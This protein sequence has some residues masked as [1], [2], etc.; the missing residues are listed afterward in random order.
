M[1]SGRQYALLR[2]DIWR[3]EDWRDLSVDAQWLYELLISQPVTSTAGVLPLQITKWARC[4]RGMTIERVAAAVGMLSERRYIVIDDDTEEVLVRSYIRHGAAA[5][6]TPNVMLSALR[7]AVSVQSIELRQAL[8]DEIE[9]LERQWSEKALEVILSL[10]E[11]L[12]KAFDKPLGKP[13]E[14]LPDASVQVQV[15][16][17]VVNVTNN[18]EKQVVSVEVRSLVQGNVDR[19][20]LSNKVTRKGL[21]EVVAAM[22]VDDCDPRGIALSLQEWC[23]RPDAYPGHLPHIYTELLKRRNGARGVRDVQGA[24]K[25]IMVWEQLRE[26][27]EDSNAQPG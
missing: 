3:D 24:D 15:Q 18:K 1:T 5:T 8:L 14:S 23:A 2:I 6:G 11:S 9:R 19:P 20:L 27:M 13:F 16:V 7:C 12:C 25:T 22:L 17:P 10:R 4:A 26:K 21:E